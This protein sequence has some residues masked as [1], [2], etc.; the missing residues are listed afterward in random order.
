[1]TSITQRK[2]YNTLDIVPSFVNVREFQREALSYEASGNDEDSRF[3]TAAPPGTGAY[4]DYWDEQEERCRNGYSVGGV[5]VTGAHY[6]YL[7]FCRIK[8]TIKEGKI[9]RK[10]LA[11]PRFLD[12]D[13]YFFQE[14]EKAREAGEGLIVAKSRRKGFSFKTGALVAHQYTFYRNSISLIGAYLAQYSN[15]TMEMTLEMLNFNQLKTDFGKNRIKDTQDFI[16]SGFIEDGITRGFKSEVKTLTFKDNFSA[17][18]GLTA[19]LMLFEEAGKWPNLIESYA[20]T[21]PV[22]RDGSIMT[23]MPIIFGTGGDMDSGS[24]DFAEMFYNPS[25]YWLRAYENIYDEGGYGT[26]CGLF[27]DDHWYK[28]GKVLIPKYYAD[29]PNAEPPSLEEVKDYQV[30]HPED[31]VVVEAVD[32]NGNSHRCA[33]A[34]ELER[35]REDKR[36]GATKKNWEK[37]I[38]QYPKTPREAFLRTSGNLF[39]TAELN[40][41]LGEL[42]VSKK[43]AGASMVGQLFRQNGEIKWIPDPSLFPVEK[44]PHKSDDNNTGCVVIWEHPWKNEQGKIPFGM[45]I[46]GTDPYDQDDS[47]TSSLGSTFIYKTFTKFDQTYNIPVAEYTGRPERAE[48]YYETVRNLLEYYNAQTLYENQLKGLKIYFEQKKCLNLLKEQPTILA[49]IIKNSKVAR[50]YGIHMTSGIKS[51][52]EIYVRDWLLEER[53]E[54]KDGKKILNLHTI[55]SIP[56]IQELMA[57]DSKHGNFDRVMAFMC[58]ILHSHENHKIVVES[59]FKNH[60]RFNSGIFDNKRSLFKKSNRR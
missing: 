9:E 43:A 31:M 33:A 14:V 44:F 55:Y 45:Y 24:V 35:E 3:Y 46:A 30:K 34:I 47:T 1:M 28:P 5:R 15:Q 32:A 29:K 2:K 7:N 21:A 12:V 16:K 6:F 25:T 56:L 22:F 10:I 42:E 8:V 13:Y 37:Y 26:S 50:G 38:T 48:T 58:T 19:D 23:G 54:D 27:I 41:W 57:Y 11:F 4:K 40:A 39:P 60:N 59:E 52:A 51:Q 36:R 49:D 17:A 53:G 18:I 20:I